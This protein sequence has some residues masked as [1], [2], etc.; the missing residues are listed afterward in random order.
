MENAYFDI[1]MWKELFP[2]VF[3]KEFGLNKLKTGKV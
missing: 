2:M 1:P 3:A